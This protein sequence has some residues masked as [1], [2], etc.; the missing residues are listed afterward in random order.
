MRWFDASPRRATP[1]GHN[2][3]LLHST[4]SRNLL[5]QAPLCVRG[6]PFPQFRALS[7]Q[8]CGR[9]GLEPRT[10][11]LRDG[12]ATRQVTWLRCRQQGELVLSSRHNTRSALCAAVDRRVRRRRWW[13][14]SERRRPPRGP[15]WP[16]RAV[17]SLF[18]ASPTHSSCRGLVFTRI[19]GR[20]SG[21]VSS[22]GSWALRYR[23]RGAGRSMTPAASTSPTRTID[24]PHRSV[25][26]GSYRSGRFGRRLSAGGWLWSARLM[27]LVRPV[28]HSSE[29]YGDSRC[30]R[31]RYRAYSPVYGGYTE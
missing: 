16:I 1:K 27:A 3:H 29:S 4:A 6:A 13:H 22:T 10:R 25:F 2:L 14:G 8:L 26:F 20:L 21:P 28:P 31:V 7:H 30:G 5:H 12:W 18:A 11:G 24:R 9:R 17:A 19:V 23:I 15:P